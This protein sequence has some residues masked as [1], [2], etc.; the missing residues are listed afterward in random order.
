MSVSDRKITYAYLETTNY[1]N[2]DCSF[3]NRK[4]VIGKL[5]HMEVDQF[6]DLLSRI[7]HHPITEAKL[8][9][10]GEPFLHPNFD[11]IC[12]EFK[13]TFPDAYLISATNCQ[14]KIKDSFKE[15]LK[16]IDLLYFSIDGFEESYERDRAPAK[17]SKLI[18]FLEETRTIN[19][20]NCK[21]VIN[22]VVNPDNVYDIPKIEE[23][24]KEYNLEELR[25]NIAQDWSEDETMVFGYTQEQIQYLRD[26][27]KDLVQGKDIWDYD[28]CFWVKQGLYTTVE[29]NVKVCCMNTAA[30]PLGN[31]FEETIEK[32]HSSFE[33]DMIK[34][35]CQTKQPTI[36]C[37]NC[38]YKELTSILQEIK[39]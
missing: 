15:S 26:N 32:I 22:Y 16:Y 38:S 18:N 20:H 13:T 5:K 4:D 36:H 19:R 1:C 17:W 30:K 10:M 6:K 39:K 11:Q 14:Y 31:I 7:S 23:L 8:M 12:K 2:L 21:I 24:L 3:C 37:A 33:Y 34:H 27:Y 28:S 29:G 9:G 35:G 25:L